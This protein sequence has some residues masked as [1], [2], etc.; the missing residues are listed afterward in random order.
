MFF[1]VLFGVWV[2]LA[3]VASVLV[4]SPRGPVVCVW[5]RAF[6]HGVVVV[7]FWQRKVIFMGAWSEV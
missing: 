1:L 5:V 3:L 4:A 2:D 7:S 6:F